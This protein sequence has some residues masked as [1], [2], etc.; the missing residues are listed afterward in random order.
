MS[1]LAVERLTRFALT[2]CLL[3]SRCIAFP[4]FY[5]RGDLDILKDV[6]KEPEGLLVLRLSR[7]W[8][9]VFAGC[10]EETQEA[11]RKEGLGPLAQRG[12][13]AELRPPLSRQRR[14]RD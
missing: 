11:E 4:F 8:A 6:S 9:V 2:S 3:F 14:E 1:L 12:T 13:L 10:R 7:S 5:A